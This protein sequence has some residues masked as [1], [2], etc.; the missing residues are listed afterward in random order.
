MQL[1]LT[2]EVSRVVFAMKARFCFFFF[3]LWGK[4]AIDAVKLWKEQL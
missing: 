2:F 3:F 4:I 1:K